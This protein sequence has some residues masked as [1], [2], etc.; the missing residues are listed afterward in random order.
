MV[1]RTR[2]GG[3][4]WALAM[5]TATIAARPIIPSE[6]ASRVQGI[7][8]SLMVS[9]WL[10]SHRTRSDPGPL[11]PHSKFWGRSASPECQPL[12]VHCLAASPGGNRYSRLLFVPAVGVVPLGA[13]SWERHGRKRWMD[14]AAARMHYDKLAIAAYPQ[15]RTHGLERVCMIRSTMLAQAHAVN[16]KKPWTPVSNARSASK[17]RTHMRKVAGSVDLKL[18]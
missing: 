5:G 11:Y 14:A 12:V 15:A 18:R 4:S 16:D 1:P 6:R 3:A 9:R 10:G 17:R 2:T 13:K 7:D 8:S